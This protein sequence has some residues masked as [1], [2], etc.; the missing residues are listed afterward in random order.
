M[1]ETRFFLL[2]LVFLFNL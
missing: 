2:F 1:A